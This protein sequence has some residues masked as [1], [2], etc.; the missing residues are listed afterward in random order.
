MWCCALDGRDEKKYRSKPPPISIR[1]EQKKIP[2][3][4]PLFSGCCVLL[5]IFHFLCEGLHVKAIEGDSVGPELMTWLRD[6]RFRFEVLQL[7][8]LFSFT[9]SYSLLSDD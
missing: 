6:S 4:V 8:T 5:C 2:C 7:S 9:H 1:D 3:I